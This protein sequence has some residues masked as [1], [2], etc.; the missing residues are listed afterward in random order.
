M[1]DTEILK[2]AGDLVPGDRCDLEGDPFTAC[3]DPD[4]TDDLTWE[5]E[6]G[7][8]YTVDDPELVEF[9]GLPVGGVLIHFESDHVIVFPVDHLVKVAV[10]S[11]PANVVK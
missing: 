11:A 1:S 6:Y 10:D 8:V 7:I 4:C 5:F 9:W 2:R 3:G